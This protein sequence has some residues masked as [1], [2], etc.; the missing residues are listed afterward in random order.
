MSYKKLHNTWY[1]EPLYNGVIEQYSGPVTLTLKD[2]Q[3]YKSNIIFDAVIP[4]PVKQIP[5]G[6]SG[7]VYSDLYPSNTCLFKS[8]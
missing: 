8:V 7:A 6:H 1:I 2:W 4:G 5:G 3:K